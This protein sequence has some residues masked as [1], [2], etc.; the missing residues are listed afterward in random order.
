[1]KKSFYDNFSLLF[2]LIFT[3]FKAI[4]N[5]F[6]GLLSSSKS[7][8]NSIFFYFKSFEYKLSNSP[9]PNAPSAV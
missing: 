3:S 7:L 2:K 8:K 1:M 5:S 6:T 4:I 9:N